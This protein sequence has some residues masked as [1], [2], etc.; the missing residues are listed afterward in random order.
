LLLLKELVGGLEHL[1]PL[2]G[3]QDTQ[4]VSWST[5]ATA[6]AYHDTLANVN[7][8]PWLPE[9]HQAPR[10]GA[11]QLRDNGDNKH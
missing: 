11:H 8:Q 6:W 2:L 7:T 4:T 3:L 5:T 1:G 9:T 10:R